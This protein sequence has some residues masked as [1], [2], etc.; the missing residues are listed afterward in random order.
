MTSS[1]REDGMGFQDLYHFNIAM[2]SKEGWHLLTQKDTLFYRI[3]K[4]KYFPLGNFLKASRGTDL[5]FFWISIFATIDL[6]KKGVRWRVG[7]RKNIFA[8]SDPWILK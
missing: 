4:A 7:D 8:G 1:K 2:L 6:L 5:S 3:F